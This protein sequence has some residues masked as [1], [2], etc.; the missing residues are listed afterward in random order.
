MDLHPALAATGLIHRV[1]RELTTTLERQLAPHEITAQQA[2]LLI[3]AARGQTSP[4]QLTLLLGT[5]TAGMTRLLDRLEA[6]GLARRR[7]NPE[8]RRALVIEVTKEGQA[9]VPHVAPV[10]GRT[11]QHLL[12]GFSPAEIS[13]LT[14]LLQRMLANLPPD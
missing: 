14:G 11:A 5:D 4:K 2:A 7:A 8:D 6:K 1:S 13:Q 9:L 10:F 12:A 3:N